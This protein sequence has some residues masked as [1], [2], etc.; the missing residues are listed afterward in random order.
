MIPRAFDSRP[1]VLRGARARSA[2]RARDRH[3]HA[4]HERASSSWSGSRRR[5]PDIPVIV[6]TAHSDL[7]SA[8][9]AYQSGAFEYLPK[10]FDIDEAMELVSRAARAASARRAQ[11]KTAAE[12]DAADH[13]PGAGDAGRVQGDRPAVALEHDRADHGRVGHRQGARRA[14]VARQLA[15]RERRRSSRSTRPRSPRSCSSRSCSATRKARSR[16]RPSGVSADS[17]KPNGGTLFLDEI[18]DMSLALQTRLLRVLAESEFFR[19]GGQMPIRVDVRVIAATHQDLAQ[20][21][22]SRAAF[23]RT[24]TIGSTSCGS[25]YRRCASAART[26]AELTR[27]YLEHAANG[28]RRRA[29]DA[30]HAKRPTCSA[31]TTGPATFASS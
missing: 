22:R 26:S 6:I 16:A 7:D 8:V 23:A 10:P 3:S 15:A 18:G 31:S 5:D 1:A 2:R 12:A 19:V 28:A 9:A 27:F 21:R 24:S 25:R 29:E 30:E 11:S 17:S 13:R 20:A 14:R 4:R